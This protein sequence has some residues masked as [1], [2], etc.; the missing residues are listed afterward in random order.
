MH[1]K[2][3]G[4]ERNVLL[5]GRRQSLDGLVVAG[6]TVDTRLDQNK[7]ELGIE[8]LA[9]NLEVL[10][11]VNGLLDQEVQILRDLRGETVGLKDT[12]DLVTSHVLDQTDTVGVTEDNTNL[13]GSHTL[14]GELA[15]LVGNLG[16]R[17]LQPGRRSALVGDGGARDTLTT[18]T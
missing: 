11:D 5:P 6:Q 7:T 2:R 13:G 14:L 4:K 12:D 9:V 10:A 15:N 16:R 1:R 8:I 3:E 17:N 18:V